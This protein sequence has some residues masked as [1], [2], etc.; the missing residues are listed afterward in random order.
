MKAQLIAELRM[1]EQFFNTSTRCLVE[2]D[3]GFRPAEGMLSVAEQV[4]HVAR[5]VDWFIE[6]IHSPA[7]FDMDFAAHWEETKNISSLEAARKWFARSIAEGIKTIESRSEE[8]LRSP[9]PL[10][11]VMGGAP[12][13]AVVS[14]I[15][16][17]TSHHRGALTVYSR[18]LGKTPDMPYLG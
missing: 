10:G 12:R 13:L 8:E 15:A 5:T 4:A 11:P 2:A 3:S 17:H 1:I 18:L 6:A 16:D 14:G 9:L 7:G